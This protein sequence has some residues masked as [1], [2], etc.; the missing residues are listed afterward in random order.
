MHNDDSQQ[1]DLLSVFHYI[2]GGVT[3]LFSCL[4]II[5]IVM[6]MA[7]VSGKFP[8]DNRGGVFPPV[9]GWL[10]VVMGSIAVILG[11]SLAIGMFIAGRELKRRKQRVFCMVVAGVECALMPLGTVLGVFTL[12]TL[13]KDSVKALFDPRIPPLPPG[14]PAAGHPSS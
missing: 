1:V 12:I 2:L 8:V 6:G 5:H 14:V 7:I 3:A 4:F 10:F 13:N 9:F 11:C